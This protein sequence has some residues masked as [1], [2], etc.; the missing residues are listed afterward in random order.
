MPISYYIDGTI[1]TSYNGTILNKILHRDNAPA[2]YYFNGDMEHYC[3]GKLHNLNGPAVYNIFVKN[4]PE[5]FFIY[6]IFIGI[7]LSK[8]EF[9]E[10]KQQELK[11][12]I[13][14]S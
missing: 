10:R 11:L 4:M 7:N 1:H 5:K 8:E 14:S 13:F 12:I 6:G 2:I 3:N 9:E